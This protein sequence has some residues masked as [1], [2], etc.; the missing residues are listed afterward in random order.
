MTTYKFSK[1]DKVNYSLGNTVSFTGVIVEIDKNPKHKPYVILT[2][3]GLTRFSHENF[4][5]VIK[6]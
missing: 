3:T 5:T 1:G 6:S 4:L 2:D